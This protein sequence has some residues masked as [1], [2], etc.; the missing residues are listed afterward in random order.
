MFDNPEWK[1][2]PDLVN[3]LENRKVAYETS[4]ASIVLLKNDQN[5]LPL[6][7]NQI[8]TLAVSGQ[9]CASSK[10]RRR[11]EAFYTATA[12]DPVSPLDALKKK[13]LDKI[14]N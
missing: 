5:I 6:K 11:V 2:N 4:L 9:R 13:L 10:N 1:E 14:K 12:N 3:S 7:Q 8:K